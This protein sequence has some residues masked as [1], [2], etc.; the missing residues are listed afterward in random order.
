MVMAEGGTSG[1][2]IYIPISK[3]LC[4]IF[5]RLYMAKDPSKLLQ[6]KLTEQI[7]LQNEI[8]KL[9]EQVRRDREAAFFEKLKD[10]DVV[11]LN[12]DQLKLILDLADS[13]KKPK[14]QFTPKKQL[15]LNELPALLDASLR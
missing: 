1:K 15:V 13:F 6:S 12:D 14:K 9:K 11:S 5:K 7:A 3:H 8:E 2:Y 10:K 4:N